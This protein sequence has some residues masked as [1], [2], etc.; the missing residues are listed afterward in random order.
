MSTTSVL[1]T[2]KLT[3]TVGAEVLGVDV[4][5]LRTDDDLPRL[6]MEALEEHGGG[7]PQPL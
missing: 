3:E 1:N 5:R 4:D 2:Q 6:L 7:V